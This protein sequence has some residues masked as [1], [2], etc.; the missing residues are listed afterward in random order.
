MAPIPGPRPLPVIGNL[1]DINISQA[2]ASMC[3]LSATYGPIYRLHLGG[4]DMVLLGS[5]EL[6]DE[7]FSRKDFIKQPIGSLIT[8]RALTPDGLLTAFHEQEEWGIAH[9]VL[10]SAFGPLAVQKMVPEML[11]ITSQLALK[12]ARFGDTTAINLTS[13]FTRLTLDTISL[14]SMDLRF[15][16]FYKDDLDPFVAA[17]MDLLET[18][19]ARD[20]RPGWLNYFTWTE[21]RRFSKNMKYLHKVAGDV[22]A[23]RRANPTTKQDLLNTMLNGVDPVTGKHLS[24]STIRDNMITFLI[25][26]HE[27]T[28]AMLSFLFYLLLKNPGPYQ[29]LQAEIDQVLGREPLTAEHLTRLPYAKACLKEALRLQPP[30]PIFGIQPVSSDPKLPVIVGK[31]WKLKHA[32]PVLIMNDLLH[33]DPLVYGDDANEFRPERMLD[34]NFKKLPKNC[35]KP[36]GNGTRACI[37]SDFALQEAIL[38]VAVLFQK[39][40]F[41][42]VDPNYKLTIKENV[43]VKPSNLFIYAKLRPGVDATVL[44]RGLFSNPAE[45]AD[46]TESKA[47]KSEKSKEQQRPISIFY[48]SNMGTCKGL[49]D[50]LALKSRRQGFASSVAPLDDAVGRITGEHAVVIIT[51]SYEGEPPDNAVKFVNWLSEPRD[52]DAF[53]GARF[54]VFGCGNRDWHDTFQRIPTLVGSLLQKHGATAIAPTGDADASEGNILGDFE[55]W[56]VDNFWPGIAQIYNYDTQN[57][58]SRTEEPW[59]SGAWA[60]ERLELSAPSLAPGGQATVTEMLV[61]TASGERPKRHM[62]LKLPEGTTYDV[63]DYLEVYPQNTRQDVDRLLGILKT[64][65]L[66]DHGSGGDEDSFRFSLT[67]RLE[68]NQPATAKTLAKSCQDE[69]ERTRLEWLANSSAEANLASHATTY[70]RPSIPQILE[71][72][73]SISVPA[74]QL[75]S[76]LPPLRPRQY[77]ISSSPLWSA[78]S[79]TIT[80]SLITHP[81]IHPDIAKNPSPT[82]GLASSFLAGLKAGDTVD[83]SIRAGQARFRPPADVDAAAT[84]VIMAAAG[85]GIA[86]FRGFV[87][88][89]AEMVRR[90]HALAPAVL[91]VGCRSPEDAPY[92]AELAEWQAAGAVDVRYA[93]SR[94]EAETPQGGRYYVQDRVR[95]DGGELAALWD[96][97]ARVYICGGRPVSQGI[98]DVVR[99]IYLAEAE[100]RGCGAPTEQQVEEWLV[101]ARRERYAVEVF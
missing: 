22:M 70:R 31:K 45:E 1:L 24:D 11:D 25:A 94:V 21:N 98:K 2:I 3:A 8:L 87:Q 55:A 101:E 96:R 86:P 41:K 62:E 7:V 48:G 85:S 47:D 12:W 6:V 40:D 72:F 49:A 90:G 56:Q 38:A 54:A 82:V 79:C 15:N 88:H 18:S 76:M 93:Y 52:A 74:T 53:K 42:L 27:T 65:G 64:R 32:Q 58:V 66:E 33:R 100:K 84:P 97:G 61:L 14:C 69:M 73:P 71:L 23:R 44:S 77:S 29:T 67:S 16:S 78:E 89:R 91:L 60:G 10:V 19:D 20:L 68:L 36:F 80:W 50:S 5:Q 35:W 26:G 39:F 43:T 81:P 4:L 92:A 63:G 75:V 9:R 34:E 46:R 37:G 28:S 59:T 13:D 30:I 99:G 17:F 57:G 51:A 95:E 83:I